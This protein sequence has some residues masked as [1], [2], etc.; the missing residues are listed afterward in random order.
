[1]AAVQSVE[2]RATPGGTVLDVL[3]PQ[4]VEFRAQRGDRST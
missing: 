3:H 2:L 4:N 1:V